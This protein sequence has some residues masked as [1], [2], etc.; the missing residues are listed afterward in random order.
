MG[1]VYLGRDPEL[2]RR[3]AVKT[4]RDMGLDEDGQARF[5][6]RFRN[7]ARIAAHL[8]HPHIVQIH[9]VGEDPKIGPY[10]VFEYVPGSTLKT[11]LNENGPLPPAEAV[12]LAS[13]IS[14]ALEAA[15]RE[16][17]IHRDIKPDNLFVNAGVVKLGDFGIARI[18]NADVTR[19]GQFLGTPCYA[20]PETLRDS[21]YG[22]SSDLFSFAAV[23]YEAVC[24]K[25]AFP[26]TEAVQVARHILHTEPPPPSKANPQAEIPARVDSVIMKGLAKKPSE[27]FESASAFAE[28]LSSAY[29][30]AGLLSERP[31]IAGMPSRSLLAFLSV[32]LAGVIFAFIALWQLPQSSLPDF[33]TTAAP[34]LPAETPAQL[35]ALQPGTDAGTEAI[36]PLAAEIAKMTRHER[37]EAA[38]DELQRARGALQ[39]GDFNTARL[40]TERAYR[41]DPENPDIT[42]LIARLP[43]KEQSPSP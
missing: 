17:V 35:P 34:G 9:D 8:Q 39:A 42:A 23:M 27:R 6:Q 37:E 2:D 32:L 5:L 21:I 26:G 3:V 10:L 15:H 4:V 29:E 36:D 18:P 11:I 16:G 30:R 13:Q 1:Y 12:A 25:R 20:A 31:S 43:A 24:G 33:D 19:E 7:E 28:A 40:A 38:K 22:P 14:S 41:F